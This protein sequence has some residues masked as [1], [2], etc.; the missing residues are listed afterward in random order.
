VKLARS[1]RRERHPGCEKRAA[2]GVAT[3]ATA[4][5]LLLLLL[6]LLL[7]PPLLLL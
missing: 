6:L 1:G 5:M 2:R 3:P 4:R 7:P